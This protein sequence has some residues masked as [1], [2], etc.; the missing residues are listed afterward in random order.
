MKTKNIISLL[1]SSCDA[2][3]RLRMRQ[4]YDSGSTERFCR[5]QARVPHHGK[6]TAADAENKELAAHLTEN[7]VSVLQT[8]SSDTWDKI[9]LRDHAAANL[10]L[11]NSISDDKPYTW[12]HTRGQGLARKCSE[13]FGSGG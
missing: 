2:H 11:E 9:C 7:C 6:L 8:L 10:E 12:Q 1:F 4:R 5:N 13:L 3:E